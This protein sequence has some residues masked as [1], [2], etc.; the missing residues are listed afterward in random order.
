MFLLPFKA[1]RVTYILNVHH[2][3]KGYAHLDTTPYLFHRHMDSI[4]KEAMLIITREEARERKDILRH[5]TL[6]IKSRINQLSI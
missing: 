2:V 6:L 5:K 1:L 3:C 4:L